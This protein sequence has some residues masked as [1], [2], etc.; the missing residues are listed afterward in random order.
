[1]VRAGPQCA[2]ASR[3]SDAL[4]AARSCTAA[5]QSRADGWGTVGDTASCVYRRTWDSSRRSEQRLSVVVLCMLPCK[6]RRLLGRAAAIGIAVRLL[7]SRWQRRG[8][9]SNGLLVVVAR[10]LRAARA[11][12]RAIGAI[13]AIA[14]R[15]TMTAVQ[16]EPQA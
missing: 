12:A 10:P 4:S 1:M 8:R 7:C 11:H 15:P 9:K 6:P 13:A 5:L 2:V 16:D 3:E 14:P